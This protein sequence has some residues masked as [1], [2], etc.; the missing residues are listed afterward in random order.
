MERM[1][2][3]VLGFLVTLLPLAKKKKKK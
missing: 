2:G 1:P 3:P